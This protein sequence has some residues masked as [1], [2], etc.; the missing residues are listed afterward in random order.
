MNICT[1]GPR[2]EGGAENLFE[3]II[4][5]KFTNLGKE[6]GIQVQEAQRI[7]NRIIPKRS[8]PGHIV[9]KMAKIEDRES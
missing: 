6:T 7:P 1:S 4:A 5:E 9:I 8:A 2:G 3:E